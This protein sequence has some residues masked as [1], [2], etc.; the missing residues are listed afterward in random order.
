MLDAGPG[1]K[2]LLCDCGWVTVLEDDHGRPLDVGR[3]QRT[4]STSLR[5]ALH[6]RD[7]GC[8]FPG[9]QRTRYLDG[10]HLKHWIDGGDTTLD[11]MALLCTHHHKLLHLGGFDRARGRQDASILDRGRAHD[12]ARRLSA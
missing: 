11:N 6:A 10:H 3:K 8:T 4:V 2:R 7:R 1:V 12:S 9:C 5:R